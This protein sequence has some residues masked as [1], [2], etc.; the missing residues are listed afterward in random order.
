MTLKFNEF[1]EVVKIHVRAKC[2]I[3]KCSR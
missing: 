3:A 2:Q 1:L